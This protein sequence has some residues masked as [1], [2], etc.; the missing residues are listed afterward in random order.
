MYA[1]QGI[2]ELQAW[3]EKALC[4]PFEIETRLIPD[5]QDRIEQTLCELVDDYHCHLVLTTGGTD[6]Q[7]AMSHLMRLSRWQ[8]V[9]CRD[10]VNK[11]A[12]SVCISSQRR[13]YRVRWASSVKQLNPQSAGAT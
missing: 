11:C 10:L 5:E 6:R 8:I 13:F 12:K 4:E 7:N 3:L 2:P 1:D 9:K